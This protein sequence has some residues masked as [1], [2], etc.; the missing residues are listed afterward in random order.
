MDKRLCIF[1]MHDEDGVA[2]EYIIC[3][4]KQIKQNGFDIIV[5]VNGDLNKQSQE[6]IREYADLLHFRKDT[7][8]DS[9]AYKEIL[10]NVLG[11]NKVTSFAECLFLNDT[12][13]G[14]F[15]PLKEILDD[16]RGRLCDFWG[17]T[18]QYE[19][20]NFWGEGIDLPF[21]I[22]PYFLMVRQKMLGSDRFWEFW[23]KLD[24]VDSYDAAVKK[25]EI[26][27]TDYFLAEGFS[28]DAFMKSE[29]AADASNSFVDLMDRPAFLVL[30][31]GLPVLKKR[32]FTDEGLINLSMDSMKMYALNMFCF[33]HRNYKYDLNCIIDYVE[34]VKKI[35][36]DFQEEVEFLKDKLIPMKNFKCWQYR[37][38]TKE[39]YSFLLRNS[40]IWIYGAGE[41]ARIVINVLSE[42][43]ITIIKGII[44]SDKAD[45]PNELMSIP[46]YEFEDI[47]VDD[48]DMHVLIAVRENNGIKEKLVENGIE[49]YLEAV[50]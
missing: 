48:E 15:V 10:L 11:R 33:I 23:E 13:F 40:E 19:I 17:L 9:M 28:C 25:F 47:V 37:F 22:Q 30:E 4:L 21:H 41:W 26:A 16:M 1:Q 42:M 7:G 46:V 20:K 34:R 29:N 3:W 31:R 32:L 50:I 36:I 2:D 5:A 18:E 6:H 14:P 38:V 44:V 45:N 27:F 8:Y 35:N 49:N 39:V 24:H 12:V 43:G